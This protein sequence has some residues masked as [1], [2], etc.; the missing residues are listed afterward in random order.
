MRYDM[1]KILLIL[2]HLPQRM[3][4]PYLGQQYIAASLIQAGHHVT[5]IDMAAVYHAPTTEDVLRHVREHS[6]DMIGMT[7]FTYNARRGYLLA[8]KLKGMTRLLVAGGPHPTVLPEEPLHHGFDVSV[9]GE[10]ELAVREITESVEGRLSLA[11]I[12]GIAWRDEEGLHRSTPRAANNELDTLSFPMLSYE[13]YDHS[14]YTPQGLMVPGG[15]MTSRGCPARCTFCANY[16]TGRA[17]RWRSAENVVREMV[18]LRQKHGVTHFPFW[19][20]AFTARRPRL[21]ALCDAIEAEPLLKGITW[22]CITPGNMVKPSDLTRMKAVGCTAVNFGLESGDARI[23]RI[24]QKGTR[25]ERVKA[26]L[27]AAHGLGMLTIVNFMFGFPEETLESLNNTL[28]WMK[29]LAPFTHYFNN[30]GVLVPFPGTSIYDQWK[31]KFDLH[32]WWLDDAKIIDEPNPFVLQPQELQDYLEWDPTLDLDFFRYTPEIREKIAA[33][34]R[35]KAQHNAKSMQT[36][37]RANASSS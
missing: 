13:S 5:C 29:D 1:A 12:P 3:G 4:A 23:L 18:A 7:L 9:I 22:T 24:I 14:A 2:P 10:G 35:F 15:L 36:W 25:P 16:V 28:Q 31:N 8:Q 11:D 19:D 6:P 17:Y 33:C 30:R 34:V 20:D 37:R 21:L 32:E 27:E 26:S